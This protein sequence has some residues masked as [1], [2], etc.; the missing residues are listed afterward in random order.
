MILG[1]IFE[2]E[3]WADSALMRNNKNL[4]YDKKKLGVKIN[5]KSA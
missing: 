1:Q 4:K 2:I 3:K 5:T